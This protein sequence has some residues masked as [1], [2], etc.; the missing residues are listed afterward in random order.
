[1]RLTLRYL[2]AYL[3]DYLLPHGSRRILE[4][5]DFEAIGKKVQESEFA[6]SLVDRIRDVVRRGR[7]GAPSESDRGAGLDPNTVAEYLDH[8]LPDTRVPDFEKVCLESDVHLAE[9]AC[10]H[11]VLAMVVTEPVEVD[12]EIRQQIYQLPEALALQ[13][14]DEPSLPVED[15]PPIPPPPPILPAE[16]LPP[17]EKISR[18]P[19]YLRSN[20]DRKSTRLNSSH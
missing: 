2:L 18:T 13:T 6:R 11:Q 4:P 16:Q 1:M 8:A 9:V 5:E 14:D 17:L 15:V 7:L 12:D 20:R 3:D 10:C 19:E